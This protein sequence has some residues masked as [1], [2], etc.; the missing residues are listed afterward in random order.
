MEENLENKKKCLNCQHV[1]VHRDKLWKNQFSFLTANA[2]TICSESDHKIQ[3]ASHR[4]L[5]TT[6]YGHIFSKH[7][8]HQS[9]LWSESFF[10]SCLH[11]PTEPVFYHP[12]Q[13]S[14]T[15]VFRDDTAIW[16]KNSYDLWLFR[17]SAQS[18]A[19]SG[20]SSGLLE[21]FRNVLCKGESGI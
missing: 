4:Q 8:E 18:Q 14:E 3:Y 1:Y 17:P 20:K 10:E 7:T 5:Y 11:I 21:N 16:R 13:S 15:W 19:I 9:V 6:E 12:L 2:K